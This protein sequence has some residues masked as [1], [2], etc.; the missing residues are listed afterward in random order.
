M[1]RYIIERCL[2]GRPWSSDELATIQELLYPPSPKT[3]VLPLLTLKGI[4]QHQKS[5]LVWILW[6]TKENTILGTASLSA[7]YTLPCL[8]AF[9]T[10]HSVATK[11]TLNGHTKS[12]LYEMLMR[13]IIQYASK[14]KLQYIQKESLPG[15]RK[16][17]NFCRR[18]QF[19]L[20]AVSSKSVHSV[21][22]YRLYL[23]PELPEMGK[24]PITTH[25]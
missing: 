18:S 6:D 8:P 24:K 10:I 25:S 21:H 11:K 19:R 23:F 3:A 4:R 7:V 14:K 5:S 22:I 17:I 12:H 16:E 1:E 2:R 9:G 20:I 15:D 13:C